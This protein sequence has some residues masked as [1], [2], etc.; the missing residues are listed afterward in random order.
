MAESYAVTSDLRDVV[1]HCA[2]FGR[3]VAEPEDH[4]PAFDSCKVR[5]VAIH[6]NIPSK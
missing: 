3:F 2:S 4:L 5:F 1:K 6:L